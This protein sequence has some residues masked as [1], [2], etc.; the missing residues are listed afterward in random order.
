MKKS[1]VLRL[2]FFGA[3]S[4]SRCCFSDLA[5]LGQPARLSGV[6]AAKPVN[7]N[8][9]TTATLHERKR[10]VMVGIERRSGSVPM[11]VRQ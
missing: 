9:P 5:S 2:F 7:Q 4:S 10:Q 11:P 1:T 6:A 3:R 8:A